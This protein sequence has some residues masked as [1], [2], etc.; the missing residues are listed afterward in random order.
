M[1]V[2]EVKPLLDEGVELRLLPE[3]LPA[4]PG[5]L[6]LRLPPLLLELREGLLPELLWLELEAWEEDE[7]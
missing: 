4:L 2:P 6:E 1:P 3:L 5:K 7:E